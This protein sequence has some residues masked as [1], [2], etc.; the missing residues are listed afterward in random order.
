MIILD[1]PT[2]GVDVGAKAEIYT[3]I[4]ALAESGVGV[5]LIS[6]EMTELIAMC[7]RICVMREGRINRILARGEFS[8]D[9]IMRYA[10]EEVSSSIWQR[11]PSAGC[12]RSG[13]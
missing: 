6:S 9:T 12:L 3:I 1:E 11:R 5:L 13:C 10:I 2:Q 4:S 7:D 8:E